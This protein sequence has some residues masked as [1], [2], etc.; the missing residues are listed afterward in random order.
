MDE[1]ALTQL[2][3]T[4]QA[5]GFTGQRQSLLTLVNQAEDDTMQ[6]FVLARWTG[7]TGH[8]QHAALTAVYSHARKHAM[9]ITAFN[10]VDRVSLV[11]SRGQNFSGVCLGRLEVDANQ[12]RWCFY[13]G[14]EF[15][16]DKSL[17]L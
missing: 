17:R 5:Q 14:R 7:P 15:V 9:G 3:M 11:L 10:H 4:L 2:H 12:V 1:Q 16:G 13:R 8:R 6:R